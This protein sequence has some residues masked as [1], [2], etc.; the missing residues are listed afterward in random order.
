M[1]SFSIS[2]VTDGPDRW[3]Q[4]IE[5]AGIGVS[6]AKDFNKNETIM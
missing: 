3:S 1:P 5:D 4:G 6:D 2:D